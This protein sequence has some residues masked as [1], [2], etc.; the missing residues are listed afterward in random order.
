M[1]YIRIAVI[2]FWLCSMGLFGAGILKERRLDADT[3]PVITSDRDVLEISVNYQEEDLLEGLSAS[4]KEDGDLTGN[5]IAGDFSPFAEKGTSKV[6]YTVFDSSNQAATLSRKVKFTDYESPK[7]TL[8]GPL[9]FTVSRVNDVMDGI[10]AVDVLDGDISAQVKRTDYDL[11]FDSPGDYTINVEVLNSLGDREAQVL[12]VHVV[13]TGV[14]QVNIALTDYLIYLK[15]GDLFRPVD[16]FD[17]LTDYNG[18]RLDVSMMKVE[19]NVDTE[20]AG[21]YEVRY[22]VDRE[23]NQSGETW[24]IVIVR[25]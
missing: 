11:T 1:K 15:K 22:Y 16:Y 18:K 9:V 13:D 24:M 20:T 2:I 14:Q 10:G 8:S 21:C 6:N 17:S 7:L 5:I 19:S 3:D 23:D 25:E 4:D 12:P